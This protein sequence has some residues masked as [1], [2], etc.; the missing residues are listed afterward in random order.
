MI[1]ATTEVT[2]IDGQDGITPDML[3]K[4][5]ELPLP[6]RGNALEGRDNFPIRWETPSWAEAVRIS[7]FLSE[8]LNLGGLGDQF[9]VTVMGD[10]TSS[11]VVLDRL[12]D[13]TPRL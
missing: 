13:V 12:A 4:R 1:P 2:V 6:F 8:I 9:H 11:V 5:H 7:E 3:R 10:K